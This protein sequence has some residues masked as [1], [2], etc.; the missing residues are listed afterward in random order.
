VSE[1]GIIAFSHG[2]VEKLFDSSPSI[3]ALNS[4]TTIVDHRTTTLSN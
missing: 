4:S 3:A 2:D 1:N